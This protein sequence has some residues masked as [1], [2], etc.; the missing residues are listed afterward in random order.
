LPPEIIDVRR[1]RRVRRAVVAALAAVSIGLT[2]WCG[3]ATYETEQARSD[4][5]RVQDDVQRRLGQ[6]R[7]FSD[8]IKVQTESQAIRTQLGTLFVS[9]LRWSRLLTALGAAA[10]GG[11]KVLGVFGVL[12][13][14]GPGGSTIDQLPS[15]SRAKVV[16]T[17]T[18][19]ASGPSGSVVAEYVDA[20][21]KVPGLSNPM[22]GDVN[23]LDG[24]LQFT[25]R[26]DVTDASLGGRYSATPQPGASGT[27]A[28]GTGGG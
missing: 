28:S 20:L 21:G 15:A 1:F 19:T 17:L 2:S 7:A 18:V 14:Q 5:D 22:L 13:G 23:Q 27:G 25:V 26:L 12:A 8:V 9:D 11:V 3:V 16:G 4:L 24:A 6:Q 10:P